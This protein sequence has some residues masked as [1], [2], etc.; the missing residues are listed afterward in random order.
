[1]NN[2]FP[3]VE[4]TSS[5]QSFQKKSCSSIIEGVSNFSNLVFADATYSG[6][7]SNHRRVD[8]L[9]IF[10]DSLKNDPTQHVGSIIVLKSSPNNFLI[11]KTTSQAK[12][13]GV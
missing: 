8:F 11:S 10:H 3:S 12:Y 13:S 2:I 4:S 1:M 6:C 9:K 5:F 7:I